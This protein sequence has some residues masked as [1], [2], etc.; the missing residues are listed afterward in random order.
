MLLYKWTHTTVNN[1]L[2]CI[3]AH[4]NKYSGLLY[5]QLSNISGNTRSRKKF[6]V[7]SDQFTMHAPTKWRSS[8][9]L[10]VYSPTELIVYPKTIWESLPFWGLVGVA[11]NVTKVRCRSWQCE[12]FERTKAPLC[13]TA[14]ILGVCEETTIGTTLRNSF[15]MS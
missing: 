12:F 4:T 6:V 10:V 2:L 8:V 7:S 3:R 11:K 1:R 9:C 13:W 14:Q 15:I 5:K